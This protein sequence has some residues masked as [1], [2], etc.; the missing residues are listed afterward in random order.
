MAIR[1]VFI[2]GLNGGGRDLR[3]VKAPCDCENDSVTLGLWQVRHEIHGYVRPWMVGN[4][5]GRSPARGNLKMSEDKDNH[6]NQFR[7]RAILRKIH[8]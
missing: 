5:R 1:D 6:Q 4:D 7:T 3:N 2:C 8:G